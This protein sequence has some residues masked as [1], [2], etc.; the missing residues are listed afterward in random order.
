MG[1]G[2]LSVRQEENNFQRESPQ[3]AV[4]CHEWID[5]LAHDRN[6][7]IR[8]PLNGGKKKIGSYKAD[9][10]CQ[11]LNT[12]FE[13]FANYWHCHTYQLPKKSIIQP[14]FKDKDGNPMPVRDLRS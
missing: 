11:E 13:F 7:K 5:W 4:G 14:T 9:G 2:F 8:F 1:L 3:F 12:V 6:I 10:F